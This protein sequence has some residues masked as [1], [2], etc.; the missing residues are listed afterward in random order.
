MENMKALFPLIIAVGLAFT[1]FGGS[2]D[3]TTSPQLFSRVYHVSTNT[4][5][6]HLKHLLPPKAGETDTALVVRFFKQKHV[7]IK[8]PE[9]VFL[10]EEKGMLF[11]RATQTDQDEIEKLV[12]K[13]MVGKDV[14]VS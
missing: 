5:V 9:A 11:V 13:I 1:S 14:P 2:T 10:N 12:E 7:E 6:P 8:P 4:F 3:Q